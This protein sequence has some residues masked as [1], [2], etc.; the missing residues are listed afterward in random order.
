VRALPSHVRD[1]NSQ[2]RDVNSPHLAPSG[3]GVRNHF[4]DICSIGRM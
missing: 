1:V 3:G 4:L 2:A